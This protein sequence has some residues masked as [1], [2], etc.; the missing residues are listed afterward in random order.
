MLVYIF[1]NKHTVSGVVVSGVVVS[2]AVVSG[3]VGSGV[4]GGHP[5]LWAVFRSTA[6]TLMNDTSMAAIIMVITDQHSSISDIL[7]HF[8]RT[9]AK[10]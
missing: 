6:N 4:D 1:I 7:Y 9:I 10:I 3:V 8:F 2:D 5:K